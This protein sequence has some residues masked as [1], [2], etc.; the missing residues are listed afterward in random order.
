MPT[1]KHAVC[2]AQL[3]LRLLPLIYCF[4]QL[5]SRSPAKI[6]TTVYNNILINN[7]VLAKPHYWCAI[8]FK[9]SDSST[10]F[11]LRQLQH[12]LICLLVC[13]FNRS[14]FLD[15]TAY[16]K[17]K[18]MSPALTNSLYSS[19]NK[20]GRCRRVTKHED[21]KAKTTGRPRLNNCQGSRGW[22]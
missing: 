17:Q 4:L 5:L 20:T 22:E 9:P 1:Y 7:E 13:L 10:S 3:R 12:F 15:S 18:K 2:T 19:M 8:T 11:S 6:T 16:K 21:Y 14:Q